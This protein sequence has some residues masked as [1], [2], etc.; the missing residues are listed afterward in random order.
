MEWRMSLLLCEEKWVGVV[1]QKEE[2]EAFLPCS[3]ASTSLKAGTT[4]WC[5]RVATMSN[6]Q[7]WSESKT[8]QESG[9]FSF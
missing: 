2:K 6:V 4:F 5:N 7:V 9:Y 8:S 3:L 1:Q